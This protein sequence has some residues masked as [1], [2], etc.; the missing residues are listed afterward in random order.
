M[1]EAEAYRVWLGL[2]DKRGFALP[3]RVVQVLERRAV[4]REWGVPPYMV[5]EAPHGEVLLTLQLLEIE[6]EAKD[7]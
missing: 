1:S 3:E 4:A 7:S 5:D 6:S 2:P